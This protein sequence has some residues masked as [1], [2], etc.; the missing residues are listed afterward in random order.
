M[1]K[2]LS[3]SSDSSQ[4]T[5]EQLSSSDSENETGL[6]AEY[7]FKM[8]GVHDKVLM[9]KVLDALAFFASYK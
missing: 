9:E 8:R 4:K 6:I 2:T 7:N 3:N 5:L 1:V